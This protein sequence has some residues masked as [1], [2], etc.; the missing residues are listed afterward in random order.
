MKNF[1]SSRTACLAATFS[2]FLLMSAPLG[3]Q[4]TLGA[5]TG[6][7][8]DASGAVV[9]DA[10][11]KSRNLATNLEVT[12]HTDSNGSFSAQNLPIGMYEVSVS[13]EGFSTETHTRILVSG[14]RT[15]RW[16]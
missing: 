6:T 12:Q 4:E 15:A 13:K 7:V 1:S 10:A 2:I 11:V 8:K 14:N 3:A 5:I 16:P 9:A